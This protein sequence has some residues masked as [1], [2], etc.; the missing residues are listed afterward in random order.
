MLPARTSRESPLSPDLGAVRSRLASIEIE[1]STSGD[2]LSPHGHRRPRAA[3][4]AAGTGA[5]CPPGQARPPQLRGAKLAGTPHRRPITQAGNA[6]RAA[7]CDRQ[8]EMTARSSASPPLPALL[9]RATG[10]A[11]SSGYG[12]MSSPAGNG[13]DTVLPAGAS[14]QVHDGL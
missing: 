11:A 2:H 7:S 9:T 5:D 6:A 12:C 3:R 13:T 10:G 4:H 8:R 1:G 14:G